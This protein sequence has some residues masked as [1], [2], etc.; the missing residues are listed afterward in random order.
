M[1]RDKTITTLFDTS[2]RLGSRLLPPDHV[3]HHVIEKKWVQVKYFVL[4]NV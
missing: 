1:Y 4:S 2:K 3:M